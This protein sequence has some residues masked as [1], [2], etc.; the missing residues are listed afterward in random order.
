MDKKRWINLFPTVHAIIAHRWEL[1]AQNDGK[2][3]GA[4]SES[5]LEHNNKLLRLIHKCL[6]RKIL[7]VLSLEDCMTRL[8]V[9]SDPIIRGAG[10][11]P[12]CSRCKMVGHYTVSCPTKNIVPQNR[13]V[14]IRSDDYYFSQLFA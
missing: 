14:D 5:G 7:Q 9:R 3:L 1:I 8:W 4:L 10:P 12:K 11:H 6:S 13:N 2:V